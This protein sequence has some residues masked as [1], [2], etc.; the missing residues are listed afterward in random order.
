MSSKLGQFGATAMVAVA[1]ALFAGVAPAQAAPIS[2]EYTD[3]ITTSTRP[4]L[5]AG[6]SARVVFTFDNGNAATASQYWGAADLVSLT[7]DFNDGDLVTT[8]YVPF[9]DGILTDNNHGAGG[10]MTDHLGALE[11]VWSLWWVL[12]VDEQFSTN[13]DGTEFRWFLGPNGMY[14][15]WGIGTVAFGVYDAM[16]DPA[17]WRQVAVPAA[18]VPAPGALA[19]LA[20]GLAGLGFMRRVRTA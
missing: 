11:R 6:Q 14:H 7:F 18:A 9:R 17:N 4:D 12:F 15:E 1:V 10:F 16:S 19:L 20:L 5:A 13:G 3:T 8:F 2:F